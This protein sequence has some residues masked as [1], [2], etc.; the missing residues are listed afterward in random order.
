MG[1]F[2][3]HGGYF[4]PQGYSRINT[5]GSH[6]ENPN[7]GVQFG[8]DEQGIP[9][10]L[11]QDES[12]Y[13][14]FVYSD[15]I[16]ANREMLK[17]Y[18]I[19]E[20]YAGKLFSEIAD[21]FVEEAED[22]PNDPIS[23]NGLNAMLV[24]LA[25]AQE[26]QKQI[27]EQKQLEKEIANLSPEEQEA[28]YQGL[29]Q[30]QS[31]E[32]QLAE[33][34]AMQ[35]QQMQQP[36]EAPQEMMQ[37]EQP[38]PTMMANGGL[39]HRFEDGTP[40]E[41]VISDTPVYNGGVLNPAVSVAFPGKTQAWVDAE[42]GPRSIKRKVTDGMNQFVVD[43]Y[44][45]YKANPA[46]Q[47]IAGV[48]G[49]AVDTVDNVMQ[50]NYGD[51]ATDVVLA[52][53]PL[54]RLKN[55]RQTA[56]AAKR[57]HN[58]KSA[59]RQ[60]AK[61]VKAQAKYVADEMASRL[62]TNKK[63]QVA[64][65]MKNM[66]GMSLAAQGI[67]A[68]YDTYKD[69]K[70]APKSKQLFDDST[71]GG[72]SLYPETVQSTTD[73]NEYDDGGKLKTGLRYAGAITNGLMGLY[74]AFQQPDHYNIQRYNPEIPTGHLAYTNPVYKPVDMNM[75]ANDVLSAG[76]GNASAIRNAGLGPSTAASLIANGYN[77]GRNL[78]TARTQ[79]ADANTQRYNSVLAARNANAQNL[80]NFQYGISSARANALN[81]AQEQNIQNN[82]T[83]QKLNYAAEAEKY[84]AL[85]QNL[86]ALA[87]DLTN[88]GNE[89]FNMNMIRTNPALYYQIGKDGAIG[90]KHSNGGLIKTYKKK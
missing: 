42:V 10:M 88:I 16:K 24:R 74:N 43:A 1:K 81:R 31:G 4:S 70:G 68:S 85:S 22:R 76:A 3:T 78:G 7:G 5:G 23:N 26:E 25:D 30:Q 15:N 72:F 61:K 2:D 80:A 56:E 79:V 49:I 84:A 62:G 69:I 46:A 34:Q 19:P 55:F 33:Q 54:A 73:T 17:K 41:V 52:A 83:Q 11:E 40:G 9:N 65:T 82:L 45:M 48:P 50:G 87:S 64:K 35:G 58:M 77:V 71:L 28:L 8:T 32:Q 20:K 36:I 47:I 59:E 57:L 39:I 90:Y 12:V 29:A 44:D 67:G 75:T 6:A 89:N 51:A 66:I 37:Q 18:N 38:Q 86:N 14:D 53:T 27:A 21:K 13:N 63:Q 60:L